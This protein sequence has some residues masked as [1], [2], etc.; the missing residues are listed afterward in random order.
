MYVLFLFHTILKNYNIATHT[1]N[2][3]VVATIGEWNF[4]SDY[5]NKSQ[6]LGTVI[7]RF[8]VTQ[9]LATFPASHWITP[10]L[11]NNR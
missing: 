11:A 3:Q 2:L 10:L 9:C 7:L 5:G 8:T 6:M 4:L 1:N